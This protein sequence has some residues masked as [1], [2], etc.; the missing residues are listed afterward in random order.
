MTSGESQALLREQ[1]ISGN[2]VFEP[3]YI[4]RAVSLSKL[5]AKFFSFT[6]LRRE[7]THQKRVSAGKSNYNVCAGPLSF[8]PLDSA[9]ILLYPAFSP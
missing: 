3:S 4:F 2:K 8:A 7:E 1:G 6:F 5:L 9:S